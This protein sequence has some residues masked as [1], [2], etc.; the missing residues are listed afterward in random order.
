[1][2]SWA[3]WRPVIRTRAPEAWVAKNCYTPATSSH[4]GEIVW[5]K[6]QDKVSEGHLRCANKKRGILYH[7]FSRPPLLC[8]L[9]KLDELDELDGWLS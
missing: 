5:R 8:Q 6:T 2:G 3:S 1:M 7:G 9:V 4:G